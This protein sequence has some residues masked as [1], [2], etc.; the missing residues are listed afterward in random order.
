MRTAAFRVNVTMMLLATIL[1]VVVQMV[2]VQ[3]DGKEIIVVWVSYLLNSYAD[4][5]L[6]NESIRIM[7]NLTN[8][9]MQLVFN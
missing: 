9:S 5:F 8:N 3:Q 2:S 7:S 4:S 6:L 1:M